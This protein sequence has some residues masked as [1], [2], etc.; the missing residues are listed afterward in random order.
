MLHF[1]VGAGAWRTALVVAAD[2][3]IL[4]TGRFVPRRSSAMPSKPK[5]PLMALY[6][7]KVVH[8]P[9]HDN[10]RVILKLD[11]GDFEIGSIGVQH[12]AAWR[13]GIDTVIPML[14]RHQTLPDPN[15]HQ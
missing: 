4:R 3:T 5:A 11:E 15:A 1:G 6:L 14:G 2:R 8:P 7:R 12:G 10:Y 9:A 13:W